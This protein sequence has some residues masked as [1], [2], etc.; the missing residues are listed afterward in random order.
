MIDWLIETNRALAGWLPALAVFVSGALVGWAT[1]KFLVRRLL[2][3]AQRTTT[4]VDDLLVDASRGLWFPVAVFLALLAALNLAPIGAHRLL[5]GE[6]LARFGLLVT[7]TLAAARFVGLWFGAGERV[8]GGP[9]AQPSLIANAARWAVILFGALFA[10]QNAGYEIAP[11]LTALGV[12]SLAVGLALQPTLSNFFAGVYLS[13]SKPI[14]VGDYVQLED[15]TEGEVVDIGWRAT[16]VRQIANNLAIVPNSRLGEMRILNYSLPSLPQAAIV[17]IGVA[18]ASD[19]E[20]VERVSLEVAH[21]V[22]RDLPEADPR[23]E[24]TARFHSFGDSA[25]LLRVV[26]RARTVTDRFAVVHE[27]VKRIKARFESEGIEIPF[28]QRV[29]H[30][31]A[32]GAVPDSR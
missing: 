25:I 17:E 27:F 30:L 28:P 14:R 24:P 18:Y 8:E 29:V 12:V 7:L 9:P 31:P 32:A 4:R 2:R 13:T 21:E 20:R 23:G 16:K 3:L 22:H 15:G 10:F 26:L 19:L 1:G 11:L 6:R 5:M